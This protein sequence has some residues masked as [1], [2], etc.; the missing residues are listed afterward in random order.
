VGNRER[1]VL[2]VMKARTSNDDGL[3]VQMGRETSF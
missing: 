1:Q 3:L 2:Q